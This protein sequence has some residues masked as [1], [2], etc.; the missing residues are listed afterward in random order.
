MLL[1]IQYKG[2]YQGLL[3][4]NMTDSDNRNLSFL[5]KTEYSVLVQILLTQKIPSGDKAASLL[6]L[7]MCDWDSERARACTRT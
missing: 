4:A 7:C 2:S 3:M 1:T 6:L 5:V